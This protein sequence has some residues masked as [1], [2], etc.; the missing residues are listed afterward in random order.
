MKEGEVVFGVPLQS[1]SPPAGSGFPH[2]A[3]AH[4]PRFAAVDRFAGAPI[5]S[6]KFR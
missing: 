3:A 4:L 5:P 2:F 6:P 1:A